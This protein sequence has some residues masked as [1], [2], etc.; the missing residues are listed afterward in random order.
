RA[1]AGLMHGIGYRARKMV[2]G[3]PLKKGW[4]GAKWTGIGLAAAGM[5]GFAALRSRSNAK[6][7]TR[8]ELDNAQPLQSEVPQPQPMAA[9]QQPEPAEGRAANEWQ[10]RVAAE[11]GMGM[12]Q[13]AGPN[14]PAQNIIPEADVAQLGSGQPQQAR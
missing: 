10:N 3:N 9:P 2:S 14:Q 12:A 11:R 4:K 1:E 6:H 8:D 5:L 13:Q 7:D